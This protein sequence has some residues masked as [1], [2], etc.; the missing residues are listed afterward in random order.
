[1]C[2]HIRNTSL[3]VAQEK[4]AHV[5]KAIGASELAVQYSDVRR[6][7][8]CFLVAYLSATSHAIGRMLLTT[9]P[10]SFLLF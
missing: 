9:L 2:T 4:D 5:D 7:M 8:R 1:M 10:S 6:S 3:S